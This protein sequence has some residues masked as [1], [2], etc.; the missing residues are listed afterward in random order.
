L[1]CFGIRYDHASVCS[2]HGDCVEPDNCRCNCMY[3]GDRCENRH[4]TLAMKK[5]CRTRC[6]WKW[7]CKSWGKKLKFCIDLF[8]DEDWIDT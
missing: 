1:M 3:Y 7:F 2:A 6:K 8:N 5:L 4:T